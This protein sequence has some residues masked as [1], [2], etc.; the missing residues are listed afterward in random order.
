[1]NKFLLRIKKQAKTLNKTIILLEGKDPRIQKAAAYLT[2]YKIANIILLEESEY[3]KDLKLKERLTKHLLKERKDKGL[4]LKEARELIKDPF[5]FGACMLDIGMADGMVG[6]SLSPTP[7]LLRPALQV[8][9]NKQ[10]LAS[11][12]FIMAGKKTLWLFADCALNPE[13]TSEG[14]ADMAYDS[15]LSFIE[16]VKEKPYVAFLSYSTR[17]SATN[18]TIDKVKN[19]YTLFTKKHKDIIADGEIQ[20]DAAIDKATRKIK[21]PDSTLTQN[22]NVFIF[23]NLDAANIGYKIAQRLGRLEAYGP[24]IQGLQK[25]VNDLSRG[26]SVDDIIGTVCITAIQSSI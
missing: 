24:I 3:F 18:P 19:A 22:A 17:G 9:R 26:C 5:Y 1:M 23:P 20:F 25:P 6:G 8:L 21:A 11:S 7:R 14:L 2:R 12:F 10:K 16:L 15:C 4:K 13:F